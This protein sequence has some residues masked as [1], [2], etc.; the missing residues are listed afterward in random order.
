MHLSRVVLITRHGMQAAE[1]VDGLAITGDK[2]AAKEQ[3]KALYTTF[4]D[5]DCTMVEVRDATSSLVCCLQGQCSLNACRK[6]RSRTP[7]GCA[8]DIR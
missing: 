3:I 2:Q 8:R 7:F 5:C 6:R 1:M 4:T